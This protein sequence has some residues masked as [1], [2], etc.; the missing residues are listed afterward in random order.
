MRDSEYRDQI[1]WIEPYHLFQLAGSV[2]LEIKKHFL[3][4]F[5]ARGVGFL[6]CMRIGYQ[7]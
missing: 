6:M 3:L 4:T 2:N 1:L 5:S 7:F